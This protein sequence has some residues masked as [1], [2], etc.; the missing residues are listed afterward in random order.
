MTTIT[1]EDA[2]FVANM[3][4]KMVQNMQNG[5]PPEEGIEKE[6]LKTVL[7]K[8]RHSRSIGDATGSKAKAKA[9]MIPID[10]DA[11]LQK[12]V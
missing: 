7:A 6:D 10:L 5:L 8:V 9:P 4:L 12:P 2:K 3:R 11:F 1:V